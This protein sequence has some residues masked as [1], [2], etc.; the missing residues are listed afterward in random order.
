MPQT[1]R[2]Q[3]CASAAMRK[4]GVAP[5]YMTRRS[6][7]RIAALGALI[8]L[9]GCAFDDIDHL[10]GEAVRF[11]SR[12]EDLDVDEAL[13]LYPDLMTK[14]DYDAGSG[15][16]TSVRSRA[17]IGRRKLEKDLVLLLQARCPSETYSCAITELKRL[18]FECA[19]KDGGAECL[20]E[21][22]TR[23]PRVHSPIK[24]YYEDQFWTVVV[25]RQAS[26]ATMQ[27]R[28]QFL[29]PHF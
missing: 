13:R 16:R 1:P 18:D 9:A 12:I 11:Q 17:V 5:S 7:V 20:S 26:G 8:A 28:L 14:D 22:R 27:A 25:E 29:G 23:H 6:I 15:T 2:L 3:Q 10:Y 21:R 19:E 24:G 4:P